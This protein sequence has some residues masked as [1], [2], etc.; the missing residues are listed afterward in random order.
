MPSIPRSPRRVSLAA[1]LLAGLACAR[2]EG[3][4][5]PVAPTATVSSAATPL[6]LLTVAASPSPTTTST[7]PASPTASATATAAPPTASPAPDWAALAGSVAYNVTYC[8]TAEGVA[9]KLDVY[10]PATLAAPAPAVVFIHGGGWS[11]GD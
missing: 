10:Y 8:T 7:P 11:E 5:S 1:L 3:T 6:A 4:P 9:L 2:G